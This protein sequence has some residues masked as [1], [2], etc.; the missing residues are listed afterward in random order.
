MVLYEVRN[1]LGSPSYDVV[2]CTAK[3]GISVRL[4]TTE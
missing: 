3:E 4:L 2:V 1:G